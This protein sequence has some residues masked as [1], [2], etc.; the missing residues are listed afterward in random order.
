MTVFHQNQILVQNLSVVFKLSF[1]NTVKAEQKEK[2][3]ATFTS[4]I[5]GT[6]LNFVKGPRRDRNAK[7]QQTE[8]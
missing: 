1:S 3:K 7:T 6:H 5:T 8:I 2:L 4:K